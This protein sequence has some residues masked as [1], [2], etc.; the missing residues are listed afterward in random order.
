[1]SLKRRLHRL[2]RKI[3]FLWVRIEILPRELSKTD[4]PDTPILYVM[5]E[6]GLSELLVLEH[7]SDRLG[8]TNPLKPISIHGYRHH[9][10]YSI[11]SRN[12]VSDWITQQKKHSRC[13]RS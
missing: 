4:F 5:A 13:C 2:F 10:V 1:M 12:P 6:R 9:S 3:L 8:V 11:A 7:I